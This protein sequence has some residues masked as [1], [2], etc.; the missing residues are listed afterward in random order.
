MEKVSY[1]I[2]DSCEG[3]D[4]AE[5]SDLLHF[6]G[7]SDL[8][9]DTQKRVFENSYVTIFIKDEDRLIGVGRALSDG[10]AHGSRDAGSDRRADGETDRHAGTDGDTNRKTDRRTDGN[11]NRKANGETDRGTDRNAY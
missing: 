4:F 5:V 2:Q 8:D 1:E 9:K 3:I 10:S 7:L 11:T 6:Y